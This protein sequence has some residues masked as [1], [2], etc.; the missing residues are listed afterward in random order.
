MIYQYI[1]IVIVYTEIL[2]KVVC[3][4]VCVCVYTHQILSKLPAQHRVTGWAG[5]S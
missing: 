3:V 1:F 5:L 4:C 2:G